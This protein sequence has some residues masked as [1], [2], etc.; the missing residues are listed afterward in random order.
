MGTLEYKCPS[1]GGGIVFD[2]DVQKMKCP[3]CDTELEMEALKAY[4][5]VLKE[6][7]PDKLEWDTTDRTE[8]SEE[9]KNALCSYVCQSCG[10]E[11]VGDAT[12]AATAC[13]FC[14]NPVVVTEKLSGSLRPSLVIPFKLDKKDAKA[15][16]IAHYAKKKLL[17]RTFKDLNHIDEIKGLYVPVWL[18]DAKADA[19]IRYHGTRI[20]HWSDSKYNYT[21]TSHFA[22]NRSGSLAFEAIPVDGS[23][24]MPDELMESIEPFDLKDGVDFQTAYLAGYFAD[25]YDVDAEHSI[26]R[27]NERIRASTEQAF[28]KTVHGYASVYPEHTDVQ[29]NEGKVHYA[30]YPVWLLNTT[31]NGQQYHFLMNGQT[32]KLAGDL[33]IDKGLSRK[34]FWQ[35]AGITFGIAAAVSALVL[36]FGGL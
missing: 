25:R 2:S 12:M 11:I 24:K 9:E 33:P 13:P 30:L 17:P 4:D 7:Q 35:T 6:E 8:W 26:G 21:E 31:W 15:A 16:L 22:L 20:A 23:E 10:G 14:G 29:M 34:Y 27:A 5:E 19:N 32:G 18:F 1:C 28:L 36:L 3:Y